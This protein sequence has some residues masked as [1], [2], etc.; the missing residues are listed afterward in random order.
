ML[1]ERV[2][3][4]FLQLDEKAVLFVGLSSFENIPIQMQIY[5]IL[6]MCV[7]LVAVSLRQYNTQLQIP[8]KITPLKTKKQT[9]E[10][11]KKISS[12][13]NTNSGRRI[14]TYEYSVEKIK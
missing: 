11:K 9:N 14:T 8:H 2:V 1:D 10:T 7:F 13:S 4:L 12:Q 6:Q 5:F 3:C